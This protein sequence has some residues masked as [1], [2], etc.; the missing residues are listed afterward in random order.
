ME[1]ALGAININKLTSSLLDVIDDIIITRS[2]TVYKLYVNGV[3]NNT[4]TRGVNVGNFSM[5]I[6]Q[7]FL[8]YK[9]NIINF[10]FYNRVITEQEILDYHNQYVTQPILLEDFSDYAVN[11]FPNKNWKSYYGLSYIN[12]K[13]ISTNIN[14]YLKKGT[15]YLFI[16]PGYTNTH[17]NSKVAYGTWEFDFYMTAGNYGMSYLSGQK[18]LNTGSA[19]HYCVN[20]SNGN[21]ISFSTPSNGILG[22]VTGIAQNTWYHI[23]ITRN[24]NNVFSIYVDDV[25]RFSVT[26]SQLTTCSYFVTNRSLANIKITEGIIV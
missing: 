6:I 15:K 22:S 16:E 11:T 4:S 25:F 13:E 19:N 7:Y 26:N 17:F 18:T 9:H 20:S 24:Y 5:N 14:Q 3:Y 2:D 10:R 23:K 21:A 8:Q 1:A 12:I